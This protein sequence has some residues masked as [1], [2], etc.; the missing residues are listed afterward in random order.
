MLKAILINP[1]IFKS[2]DVRGVYPADFN[3]NV[4]SEITKAY[5]KFFDVKK[6]VLG[7]DVRESGEKLFEAV[8]NTFIEYG[9][10][11]LDIGVVSTDMFYFTVGSEGVDG[12]ITISA[13]HNPR[14]WNGMN[15]C[16]KGAEPISS[17]TGLSQMKD[18]ILN[19]NLNL[20]KPSKKGSVKKI[21]IL[22]NFIKKSISFIDVSK[23]K[24]FKIVA[25]ANFGVDFIILKRT[26]E[27][28]NLP[29]TLVP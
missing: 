17:E 24:S 15:F 6:I 1:S 25:N 13:S 29:L 14:E 28:Y 22:D 23:I 3:E 21:D 16:K 26:I 11:I 5:I 10:D 4:A 20:E 9:V 8:K 19:K 2:Y 7:R 18:L 27:L 12:G